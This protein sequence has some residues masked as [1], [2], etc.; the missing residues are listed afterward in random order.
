MHATLF[1]VTNPVL[2]GKVTH[3]VFVA[4]AGAYVPDGIHAGLKEGD[5]RKAKAGH[6]AVEKYLESEG[7]P[8]TVFQV[9]QW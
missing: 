6:V 4:S 3:Y 8:Y 1:Q 2:Q 5:E 7:L 9:W